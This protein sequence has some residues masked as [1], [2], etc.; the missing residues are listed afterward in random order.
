MFGWVLLAVVLAFA[1][2]IVFDRTVLVK[3]NKN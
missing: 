1:G 2:G 3:K